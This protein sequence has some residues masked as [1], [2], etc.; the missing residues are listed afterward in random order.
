M[1]S[2][3]VGHLI[4]API[5]LDAKMHLLSHYSSLES[6]SRFWL[7]QKGEEEETKERIRRGLAEGEY[8]PGCCSLS[9]F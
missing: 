5:E 8:K 9:K 3:F 7:G 2:N 1:S 6:L 4:A